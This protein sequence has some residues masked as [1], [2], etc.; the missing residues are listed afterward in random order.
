VYKCLKAATVDYRFRPGVQIMVGELA[1]RLRV[2]STPVRETLIRLQAEALLETTPRRGFFAKTLNLK[3]MIDLLQMRFLIMKSAIE[4]ALA[5]CG[6]KGT[7]GPAGNAS[8]GA[9]AHAP[10][11]L[12]LGPP[13]DAVQYVEKAAEAVVA[14]AQNDVMFRMLANLNDRTHYV[15]MLDLEAPERAD[16]ARA[17]V[18]SLCAALAQKD[19]KAAIAILK[20]A[21]DEQIERMPALVKEGISRA[22]TSP[23]WIAIS[24]QIDANPA[25]L[26]KPMMAGRADYTRR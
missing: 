17:M 18:E 11:R 6:G 3:E 15:R 4:L 14:L 5:S 25:A 1:E 20:R 16:E 2:S 21:R 22:Y 24:A 26:R 19:G 12:A 23:A 8:A 7:A 13:D 10:A 9:A